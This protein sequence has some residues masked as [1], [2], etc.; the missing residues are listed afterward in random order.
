MSDTELTPNPEP[1]P[2]PFPRPIP[3]PFPGP[4]PRPEPFP[5]PL[6]DPEPIPRPPDWWRCLRLGPVSGRYE[7]EMTV[8]TAGRYALDLRMDI[9]PR[10]VNSPVIDRISGDFYQVYRFALPGR[11]PIMWRVYRESWIVDRPQANWSRCHVDITGTVRFW[12]GVHPTTNI[13]VR[14]RWGASTPAGPAEVTFTE[15]GG[16]TSSYSCARKSDCV[17]DMT[18][19]VDVCQ[20]VNSEPVLPSY[21]THWHNTRPA[22]L[23]QRVLTIEESFRE[24]GI[25]A[26]IRPDRTIIDDSAPEF[27]SWSVAELHDAMETHFSQYP[28]TWPKWQMWGLLAGRFESAGVAGI[29]FDAAAAYG[30]AGEPPDRQGFAVFRN[31]VWFNNLVEGVPANQNQAGAMRDYLYTWV[32]EA[33]HAF[34][35]LHSWN[36]NRPDSLSWMNYPW[37]YDNRNGAGSFWSN[38]RFRFDNEELIHLRHGDRASVIMGGDPWASGGH[39]EDSSGAFAQLVGDAPIEFLLRSKE[40]FEFMEPVVVE[41]R[42]RNCLSDLPLDLDTRL[43]PEYGGV[44][45]YIQRPDG[46]I[47]EHAPV[48][49]KLGTPDIQTLQPRSEA[50]QGPDRYSEHVFL[51]YGGSGFN[52]DEPGEYLVRAVYQG[53]GDVLIPSNIH[54]V[55]VGRPFSRDEE[56]IAQDFF[57]YET[58]MS[59]YLGGSSSAFLKKG[60]DTLEAVA[61]RYQQTAAGAQICL[62]LAHNLERP[63]FHIEKGKLAKTRSSS[64]TD[65][66][67]LTARA[68]EQQKRD[69]TTFTNIGYHELCRTRANLML[70]MGEKADA[71]KELR[72]LVQNLKK[73]GVN[74]SVLDQIEADAENL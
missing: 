22:D 12:K 43:N 38:F 15:A 36:K 56:R 21:D 26:S 41:F 39:L 17:R 6:P 68:A 33:G 18:L 2:G 1:I 72:T 35:L 45:V 25:S 37:R 11:P 63:F 50:T 51:S 48:F 3:E 69:E 29:M 70:A 8:P 32:H 67:A 59:L 60:M 62:V 47:A 9:D 54:R 10:Y 73:R 49:C 42:L 20:S 4:F 65:A 13:R 27:S 44:I 55:R 34:N 14:I 16:D 46:R 74:Q 66:L 23:P 57:S 28:G 52:F 5:W 64:P 30:G 31:H 40:F 61:D 7:G 53:V 71:K 19:E 24:A 58:G